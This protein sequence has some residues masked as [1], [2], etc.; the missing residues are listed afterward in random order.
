V[1]L[2][3]FE[4]CAAG[5]GFTSITKMLN[6]ADAPT[7]RPQQERPA[8]WASS[9]VREV[10]FRHLYIGEIV[11]NQSRKRDK[12]GRKHQVARPE[13]EHVVVAAPQ[14]RIIAPA[15]WEAAQIKLAARRQ[16]YHRP[17]Q[18]AFGRPADGRRLKYLLSGSARCGGCGGSLIVVSRDH[19]KKRAHFY[20]CS[21]Y[22][23]K[24]SSICANSLMTPMASADDA[25]LRRLE[26]DVL[27]PAGIE[28]VIERVVQHYT[29]PPKKDDVRERVVRLIGKAEA[30]QGR[31][32]AVI[33][34]G[35]SDIEALLTALREVERRI[36]ES[37]A[38]LR[39]VDSVRRPACGHP[40]TLGQAA[41]E[42]LVDWQALLRSNTVE[43]RRILAK[44]LNGR[45][46]FTPK[47][48]GIR[49][50]YEFTGEGTVRPILEGIVGDS[51]TTIGVPNAR[52][53]E[54]DRLLDPPD[55]RAPGSVNAWATMGQGTTWPKTP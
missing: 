33:K 39:H 15:L 42:R 53:L 50:F 37:R 14:L 46:T 31:L 4:M 49:E 44:L 1:V 22:Y 21:S 8:A 34:A 20:A 18:D 52:Q 2:R 43:A 6:A 47:R 13:Q 3:I 10:L 7:P 26:C 17:A 5:H 29:K 25:V 36:E 12:W 16:N 9:T 38:Q 27:R 55:R 54:P 23:K 30:D 11:W 19:G 28:A 45:L 32:I 51:I 48:E 35:G 41:R 24:G 40:Q